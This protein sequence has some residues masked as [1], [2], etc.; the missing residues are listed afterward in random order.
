MA[1]IDL[2]P[3]L[4]YI[5]PAFCSYQD[6]CNVGMALKHEGYAASDWESWSAKD[7]GRYH[8]GECIKKWET[9]RGADSPITGATI[10]EMAKRSGWVPTAAGHA[11]SWE[12]CIVNDDEHIVIDRNWVEGIEVTDPGDS[13]NPVQDIITYLSVI[14]DSTDKVSYV[15]ESWE[16]DGRYVP[17]N[18]GSS[19][20]T[21]GE[22]IDLLNKCNG[23]IGAVFGDT[24][25][26]GGAWIRFNPVDGNGVRNNN[27]TD[28]R[29]ALVES[30]TLEIAKQ[31]EIMRELQLP[32]A[33][34]VY[35]G[36][37]SIHAIVHV[38]AGDYQEYR[39]RV[40]ELYDICHKN[41][42]DVDVQ[43][44]NP[45]R[46]SRL[47]GIKR[48]NK[49]QFLIDTNIGHKDWASWRKWYDSQ[50]DDLPDIETPRE[51]WTHLPELA[52][53]LIDGLLRCG[54]KMM[55][56]GPSKAG[57][58]LALIE[59]VISIAEGRMWMGWQCLQ[60]KVL[61]VNLEL[62]RATCWHRFHDV[63]IGLGIPANNLDN[64]AIWNLRGK[65]IPMDK[66]VPKLIRRA[67]KER[68]TAIVID[69][70][71]KV[72]TGDENSAEQ[73]A[74]FCNQFDKIC[75][76][77]ECA[78][79]YC[80]HHSKGGQSGKAS[81]DRASGSGVFARDADALLDMIQLSCDDPDATAWRITGTL[82]EFAPFEPKNVF[83][84]YPIHELDTD[85]M[86]DNAKII[87]GTE[88]RQSKGRE[89][90]SEIAKNKATEN[91]EK[92]ENIFLKMSFEGDITLDDLIQKTGL[93]EKTIK[94]YCKASE[95]MVLNGK[96]IQHK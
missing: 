2:I 36:S 19:S 70:I 27:I 53:P 83:F 56:A 74:H 96:L 73:M 21:A 88:Y 55:L 63:Y 33:A 35:S 16:K 71:Y 48:G 4:D 90:G 47:P 25:P 10:T 78:V 6:W 37:K 40:D 60:G 75:T 5:E 22:L 8:P 15:T 77:L 28:F 49:K 45:S 81:M 68:Y 3:L 87:G 1:Q 23:D 30:D 76:E 84:R 94:R 43:D 29:Y 24:N 80:H 9:F 13:W 69:P 34:M 52:T 11:L 50:I 58:S 59:L 12:D 64:W 91:R 61:Y 42:L 89:K 20:R 38:D 7:S 44:R 31:N 62:D 82:R 54:H 66:L 85:G 93:S 26:D 39:K 41:G 17:K 57:K 14:F 86:L 72:I 32:I 95:I 67:Q 51:I 92:V 65:S 18:I 79:I 46:L